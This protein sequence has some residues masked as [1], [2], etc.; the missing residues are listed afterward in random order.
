MANSDMIEKEFF[1]LTVLVVEDNLIN[2][3]I[4]KAYLL[5]MKVKYDIACNG[6]EGL[7]LFKNKRYDCVLMD[8]QMPEMDG[9]EATLQIRNYEK[10]LGV[11]TPVIAVTASAPFEEQEHF[12][13]IGFDEYIPKPVSLSVLEYIFGKVLK[14]VYPD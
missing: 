12:K 14:K 4:M 1:K 3:K 13:K 2:Q 10:N 9:M 7:Q 11:Y 5:K 6:R 8:I